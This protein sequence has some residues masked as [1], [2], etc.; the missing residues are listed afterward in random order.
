MCKI[1]WGNWW[2]D[3]WY[4]SIGMCCILSVI[5][6]TSTLMP[7]IQNQFIVKKIAHEQ[8]F[9]LWF[10]LC[11]YTKNYVK[12]KP[13][14]AD[15]FWIRYGH[16]PAVC[17]MHCKWYTMKRKASEDRKCSSQ[18]K[19]YTHISIGYGKTYF[20]HMFL[21]NRQAIIDCSKQPQQ[22][23]TEEDEKEEVPAK[24]YFHVSFFYPIDLSRSIH[25]GWV[26]GFYMVYI[27]CV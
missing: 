17:L 8:Q 1:A 11:S 22:Q 3:R 13:C 7:W 18:L 9:V 25:V 26:S 5:V 19:L 23:N 21:F 2:T 6:C 27:V 14:V 4:Q 15:D 16:M 12:T 24:L 10:Y 20:W